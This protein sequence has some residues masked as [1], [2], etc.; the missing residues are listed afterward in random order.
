MCMI[1]TDAAIAATSQP[2]RGP[3][4][5]LFAL[6]GLSSIADNEHGESWPDV[7]TVTPPDWQQ[8]RV[9]AHRAVSAV[10]Q[11][12]LNAADA[13]FTTAFTLD[14]GLK[15][16]QIANFWSMSLSGLETAERALRSVGRYEEAATLA[17]D[18]AFR[19]AAHPARQPSQVAS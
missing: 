19:F 9:A 17:S 7:Q 1:V 15:P 8:A 12:D 6:L 3:F 5:A 10:G 18:V 2:S 14:R 13:L 4:R 16:G 11:G